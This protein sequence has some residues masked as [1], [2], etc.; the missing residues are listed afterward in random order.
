MTPLGAEHLILVT[1]A[2]RG[3]L[4]DPIPGSRVERPVPGCVVHPRAS[5]EADGRQG[6]TI[7]GLT[8]LLPIPMEDVT[9]SMTVIYRGREYAVDGEAVQWT[10][11]DGID[12]ACQINLKLGRG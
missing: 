5:V 9:A 11:L 1:P 3:P 10:Y 4:G 12:A 8:A 6:T 2:Q 7:V